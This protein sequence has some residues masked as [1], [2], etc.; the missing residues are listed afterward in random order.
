MGVVSTLLLTDGNRFRGIA[1]GIVE[2]FFF[3]FLLP[4]LLVFYEAN[5]KKLSLECFA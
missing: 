5:E 2:K 3:F 4:L 1:L